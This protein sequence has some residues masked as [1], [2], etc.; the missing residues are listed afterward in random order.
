M[1]A[2][3]GKDTKPEMIVRKYLVDYA[4]VFKLENCRVIQILFCQNLRPS[5]LLMDV[6]GMVMKGASISGY[7][8]QISNSGK[9][10][11]SVTLPEMPTTKPN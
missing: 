6:S 11:L 10:R 8:S 9:R 5:F 7:Q 4:S 1:A 2:V 3:K